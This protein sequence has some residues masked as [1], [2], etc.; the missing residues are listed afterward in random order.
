[1]NSTKKLS[2]PRASRILGCALIGLAMPATVLFG[3][4][5]SGRY[6]TPPGATVTEQGGRVTGEVRSVPLSAA[7]TFDLSATPPS[8]TAALADA[9]LEGGEPFG[10]TVRS[11]AGGRLNDGTYWFRGDYLQAIQHADSQ[12]GF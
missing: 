1:M 11:E 12:Y 2:M 4:L 8:L 6:L 7:L 9:V 5:E 10:L 3:Q